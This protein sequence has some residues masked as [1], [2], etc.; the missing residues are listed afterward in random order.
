MDI[1]SGKINPSGLLPF[2]MPVNMETVENQCEDVLY[3]MECYKDELG[4]VY[5]FAY[6]L[7]FNGIINDDRVKEY[8]IK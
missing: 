4:H 5:D 3:D 6:G 7:D 2:Q 8:E 1:V